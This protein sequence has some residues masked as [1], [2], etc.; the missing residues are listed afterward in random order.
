MEKK[1]VRQD[2]RIRQSLKKLIISLSLSYSFFGA[3]F[4]FL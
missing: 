3:S 4:K 2:A 1:H